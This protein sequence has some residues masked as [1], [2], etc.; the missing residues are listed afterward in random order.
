MVLLEILIQDYFLCLPRM[1]LKSA[2]YRALLN[3]V[4]EQNDNGEEVIHV[5]CDRQM[6][7]AIRIMFATHC[8]EVL[9]R[10]KELQ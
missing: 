3:S 9:S 8:P 10:I 4:R 5:L 6:A 2:E 7:N 1:P